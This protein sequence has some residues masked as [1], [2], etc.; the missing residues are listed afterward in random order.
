MSMHRASR[1]ERR[2]WLANSGSIS[3]ARQES[4][5]HLRAIDARTRRARSPGRRLQSLSFEKA[6][7]KLHRLQ[8]TGQHADHSEQHDLP[9]HEHV[10]ERRRGSKHSRDHWK[11]H[12]QSVAPSHYEKT[13]R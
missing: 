4:L 12:L 13:P 3:Y 2:R 9:V 5:R 10:H 11:A 6:S 7:A 8:L 1:V